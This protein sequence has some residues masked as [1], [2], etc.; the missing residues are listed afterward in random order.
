MAQKYDVASYLFA[1]GGLNWG[2]ANLVMAFVGAAYAPNFASDG[3]VSA[4]PAAGLLTKFYPLAS[5]TVRGDG[6]C[7]AG[8][9]VLPAVTTL[10]PIIALLIAIDNGSGDD[11]TFPLVAYIDTGI[12]LGITPEQTDVAITWDQSFGGVFKL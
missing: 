12:G 1:T 11:T 10:S 9:L 5:T 2:N 6:M 3:F 7:L 4:I 8:S